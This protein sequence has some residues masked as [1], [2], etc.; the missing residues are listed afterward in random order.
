MFKYPDREK[1]VRGEMNM[2]DVVASDAYPRVPTEYDSPAS[3]VASTTG[4][5]RQGG[6]TMSATQ[7]SNSTDSVVLD[8]L[9]TFELTYLYD[10]DENPSEVT[11]FTDG[12]TTIATN[13]ITVDRQ[14]AVPLEDVR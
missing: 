5:H 1:P 10:D 11:V 6:L 9:P 13:W 14:H 8:Q 3:V 12:E 4:F 2:T 7:Q